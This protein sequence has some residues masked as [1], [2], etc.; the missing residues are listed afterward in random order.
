MEPA[1]IIILAILAFV[2]FCLAV[3]GI[4]KYFGKV[5]SE[6]DINPLTVPNQL[7]GLFTIVIPILVLAGMG[8]IEESVSGQLI[9]TFV[10]F[11]IMFLIIILTNLKFKKIGRVIG[12]SILHV[13][14]GAFFVIQLSLWFARLITAIFVQSGWF[15]QSTSYRT[16][17][18]SFK[19]VDRNGTPRNLGNMEEKTYIA[20]D[21]NAMVG[22]D[23]FLKSRMASAAAVAH[24]RKDEAAR[25]NAQATEEDRILNNLDIKEQD[26]EDDCGRIRK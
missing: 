26:A 8:N 14:F 3:R 20:G 15:G 12:I 25:I 5:Y 22:T 11:G 19:C 1:V 18:F 4:Y 16:L 2:G 13:L 6:T 9:P 23:P 24:Q 17:P 21:P 10:V 7:L